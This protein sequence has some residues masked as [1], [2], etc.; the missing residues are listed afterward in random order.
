MSVMRK[1]I[2]IA[3]FAVLFPMVS[4]AQALQSLLIPVDPATS[5]LAGNT[6]ASEA[7]AFATRNN[8]AA[9]S[10]YD[11]T[12]SASVAYGMW[13]PTT[14]DNSIISA[15]SFMKLSD[16][17]GVGFDFSSISATPYYTTNSEGVQS[18]EK[19]TPSDLT[20]GLGASY[21]LTDGLSVG[22]TARFI[23][24]SIASKYSATAFGGD[25]SVLY[26]KNNLSCGA[27]VKNVGSKVSYSEDSHSL[28]MTASAGASYK[29]AGISVL[30]QADYCIPA[31]AFGASVG[32]QYSY[33]DMVYGRAGFHYG[34]ET[35]SIPTYMSVGAGV[36]FKGFGLDVSYLLGSETLENSL[37]VG[38]VVKI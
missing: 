19:F 17:I 27:V 10:F 25:I 1:N 6:V 3:L 5:S 13:A 18:N 26:S 20:V 33:K 28:P 36:N 24:S 22:L 9:M 37:L 7:S 4:N 12:V 8:S 23:H 29:I 14:L 16:K 31:S 30:A 35:K 38:I 15:A 32:L 21:L 34:D 11:K 2:I